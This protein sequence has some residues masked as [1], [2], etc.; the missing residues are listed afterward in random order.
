MTAVQDAA[1]RRLLSGED[2]VSVVADLRPLYSVQSL[3]TVVCHVKRRV[4]EEGY[5]VRCAVWIS[6]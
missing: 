2:G 3:G 5:N 6:Q 4:L 1:V